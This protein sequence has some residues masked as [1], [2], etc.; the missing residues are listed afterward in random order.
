MHAQAR[1]RNNEMLLLA[2]LAT[3][4]MLFAAFTSAYLIRRTG[5][6]WERIHFPAVMWVNTLVLIA[7]SITLE[8]SRSRGSAWL[9]ATI[10]LGVVFFLGQSA[11]WFALGSSGVFLATNPHASFVYMLSALHAVHVVGGLS[12][13]GYAYRRPEA[14]GLCG[15]FWHFLGGLWVYLIL[16][17][18]VL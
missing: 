13:L 11:A 5:A 16:L 8:V 17:L 14:L 18:R 15:A 12:A 4:V 3:V 7:S 10:G 9:A 2:V 6:D 1:A